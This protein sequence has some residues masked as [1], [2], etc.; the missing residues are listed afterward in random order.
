MSQVAEDF[1]FESFG[2]SIPLAIPSDV[3]LVPS[4]ASVKQEVKHEKST[5]SH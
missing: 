1:D 3:L 5:A 2:S 4:S